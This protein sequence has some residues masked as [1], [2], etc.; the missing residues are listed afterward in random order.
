L[1]FISPFPLQNASPKASQLPNIRLLPGKA[2]DEVITMIDP[3]YGTDIPM[4]LGMALAQNGGAMEAFASLPES[5][6]AQLI[7]RT[8]TVSSKQEMQALVREILN[9][10]N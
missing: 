4:G 5:Q 7:E 10:Q 9:G 6:R 3:K 1:F 2:T 8:H